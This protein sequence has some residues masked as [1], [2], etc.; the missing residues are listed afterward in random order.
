MSD[1]GYAAS[2]YY[3]IIYA[4]TAAAG[5]GMLLYMAAKGME[6]DTLDDFKGLNDRSPWFAFMMLIVMF[7]MA[8]VPPSGGFYAKVVVLKA[9]V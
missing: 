3:V 1:Q 7:S 9:V 4:I 6:N 8:G 2:M 5:F